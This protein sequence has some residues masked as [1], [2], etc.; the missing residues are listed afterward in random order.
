MTEMDIHSWCN[1]P[2]VYARARSIYKHRLVRNVTEETTD[3][4]TTISGKIIGAGTVDY[5]VSVSLENEKISSGRCTCL[6]SRGG[7]SVCKHMV[8]LLLEYT[9]PLPPEEE[10]A[11]GRTTSSVRALIDSYTVSRLRAL[12]TQQLRGKVRLDPILKLETSGL[13]MEFKVG[14]GRTYI[15]KD[16]PEF[17]AQVRRGDY[18]QYGKD[19]GFAHTEEMFTPRS[20]QLLA[21][22]KEKISADT[23]MLSSV[24]G[25]NMLFDMRQLIITPRD[26]DSFFDVMEGETINAWL[27]VNMSYTLVRRNPPLTVAVEGKGDEGASIAV[28]KCRIFSGVSC[29]YVC[30]AGFIYRCDEQFSADME[31]F[32]R[33]TGAS[34]EQEMT[35]SRRDLPVFCASV[36][37]AISKWVYL[38]EKDIRLEEFSPL[39][40]VFSFYMDMPRSNVVTCRPTVHYG[41]FE[42]DLFSE[43]DGR[44]NRNVNSEWKVRSILSKYFDLETVSGGMLS[45]VGDE[46]SIYTLLEDGLRELAGSGEVLA[47]DAFKRVRVLSKPNVTVGVRVESDLLKLNVDCGDIPPE[48]LKALLTSYRKRMRFHRL[49]NGQFVTLEAS[50]FATVS[51]LAEGLQMTSAQLMSG[52]MELPANRALYVDSVIKSGEGVQYSRD[53]KFR[54]LIKNMNAA[55]D[56]EFEVP[57]SLDSI[58]RTYQKTGFRWLKTMEH[59][60]FGGILAD[61]M[62][63]GKTI[64]VIAL[65]LDRNEGEKK[66]TSLIVC[67]ASL[68]YNWLSEF[69]KFAPEL[70]CTVIAG[71]AEERVGQIAACTDYDVVVTSYDLLR[72][73]IEQYDDKYFRYCIIDE[74]QYIKN[75]DTLSAKSVKAIHSAVRFALTGTPIENR[76]SELWSIFD[77][78]MPGFLYSYHHFREHIETPIIKENDEFATDRLHRMIAPFILR[79]LKKDV[80]KDLP[81]KLENNIYSRMDTE[82]SKLYRAHA[83]NLIQN[84]RSQSNEAYGAGKIQVLAELT[85]LRQICCDPALCFEDYNGGSAKLDTCMDMLSNAVNSGHKVLL[86]S[87]FT[88]MLSIIGKRLDEAGIK[89][90]TIVGSTGKEQRMSL[91]NAFNRDDTPVFLISL[92]AG[93]TGLNLTSADIVIHYD[94][95][96]NVAAQDQA[97]D[98]AHRIGQRNVVTVFK[99]IAQNTIEEKIVALQETKRELADSVIARGGSTMGDITREELIDLLETDQDR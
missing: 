29:C 7:Q 15:I 47:S 91:V 57:E 32:L 71:T 25:H 78:L 66:Q 11:E 31:N 13:R 75:H 26:L 21:F 17:V 42:I 94:P 90:Y 9:K 44:I 48:E 34:C 50:C 1:N 72:R 81:D 43:D 22:L 69:E 6:D 59:Y 64:Q 4:K 3:S 8:S 52:T 92:K 85:K 88:S 70:K 28:D 65:L 79:R 62:G 54:E 51:E 60:G 35:V 27:P 12:P 36:L 58:L 19:F 37:P 67:P 20:R 41:E 80:L 83:A 45:I 86:F 61:E 99:M 53:H 2:A 16:I 56:S 73:D 23:D 87:Q 96:W 38:R 18:I 39:P 33:I 63:L 84:L 82:Q 5:N 68:V 89:Y 30:R 14:A 77:F 74:A 97:T 76:L 93:G 49:K 98:R 24:P 40:E 95:W 55:A 10:P 46:D